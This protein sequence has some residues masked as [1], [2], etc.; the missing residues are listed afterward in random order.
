MSSSAS[1]AR[2][3]EAATGA[4]Q[5]PSRVVGHI[6]APHRGYSTGKRDPGIDR[7]SDSSWRE[8]T[9]NIVDSSNSNA[10]IFAYVVTSLGL[11]VHRVRVRAASYTLRTAGRH[12]DSGRDESRLDRS[13]PGGECMPG[14]RAF[15][16]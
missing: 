14:L 15:G 1:L 4:K 2:P 8:T 6:G 10:V 9:R 5:H 12:G 16:D 13:V 7:V 11:V 3:S